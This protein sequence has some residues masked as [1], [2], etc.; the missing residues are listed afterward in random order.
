MNKNEY[1]ND[2]NKLEIIDDKNDLVEL[3][4]NLL[5]DTK[6]STMNTKCISIPIDKLSTL[7]SGVSSLVPT[8]NTVTQ[9]TTIATEGLFKI[10]NANPGDIL[11]MAKNGNAWGAMKTASGKS[12]M[13][14]LSEA[15]P[16]TS[17]TKTV[18]QF[19]PSTVL[20]AAS[21][22]SIEKNLDE[23]SETQKKMLTFLEVEN[24]SQIE[25][26]VESLLD[27]ISNYKYTWDNDLSIAS[28]HKQVIDIQNRARKN[29]IAYQKKAT[30]SVS[31]KQ[32]I[33]TQK[34]VNSVLADLEKIFKYYKLS[35]YTFS[36]AAMLE[37]MLSGNFKE[38]YIFKIKKDIQ[39]ISETYRSQFT[40]ASF[41]LE[42]LS[43]TGIEANV[44]KGIGNANETFGKVIGNTPFI[45]EGPVDEYLQ[46]NGSHLQENAV[47]MKQKAI[48]EFASLANPETRVFEEKM[49]DMIQIFNH[50]SQISF[51]K[52]NICLYS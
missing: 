13:V 33:V 42:K 6:S 36:L 14:Q 22:Y 38:D 5:I 41:Y 2:T 34:K 39:S 18:A 30:D 45:K 31:S 48:K 40:I 28:S 11:K 17:T 25:A 12:K 10:A 21:L 51:D 32:I 52:E 50:T 16:L 47:E 27:I 43:S 3:T 9:T 8:F 44:L 1:S 26:D 23:I 24:E 15:G 37:I 7:V 20:M 35:V 46:K 19:N 4:E 49:D 29:M